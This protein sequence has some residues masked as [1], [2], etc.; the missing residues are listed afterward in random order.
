MEGYHMKRFL[1]CLLIACLVITFLITKGELEVKATTEFAPKPDEL[2]VS[3]WGFNIDLLEKNIAQRFKDKYGIN[4]VF[5][6]GDNSARLT[7]LVAKK[8]APV[9]DVVTLALDFAFRAKREGVLQPLDTE[10]VPNIAYIYNWAKDP[11]GD[12]YGVG[13]TV[14]TYKLAYRTDKIDPPISSWR[15]IWRPELK[16]RV[17]LPDLN[18]TY[19]PSTL[20]IIA[21]AW[22]GSKENL[23]PG[24]Q[25]IT[26]LVETG[27]LL[28][29][30]KRSSEA[31]NLFKMGEVWLSPIPSFAWAQLQDTGLPVAWVIPEEGLIGGLNVISVVKGTKNKYWAEK[32]ID[33][34]LSEETQKIVA[35][36]KL[37]SPANVRVKLP[38]EIAAV[39]AYGKEV[40]EAIIFDSAFVVDNMSQWL[41]RWNNLLAK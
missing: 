27:A 34:W 4:I 10:N 1:F 25:K 11:L 40:E 15:D 7:K 9:I 29:A 3:T 17:T 33:F 36:D 12:F 21:K 41:D 22:G 19:G 2:V 28:T 6:F 16:G 23:E 32:L 13:Y 31:I 24:W 20:I 5:E 35:M 14:Q 30:Y 38:P 8:E 37:D 18:T 26:E 39:H